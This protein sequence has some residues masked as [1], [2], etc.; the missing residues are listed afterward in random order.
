M[1]SQIG[2]G[3]ERLHGVIAAISLT[4]ASQKTGRN[5]NPTSS[6]VRPMAWSPDDPAEDMLA[7]NLIA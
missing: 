6:E 4:V 3:L 7:A 2:D 1:P 5:V